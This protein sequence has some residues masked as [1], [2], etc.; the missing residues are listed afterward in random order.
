MGSFC[1]SGPQTTTT[2]QSQTYT[3]NPQIAAAGTQALGMAQSAA[4]QPFQM[5]AAPVA[6]FNPFQTQAFDQYQ[7]IQGGTNPF[8]QN[9]SANMTTAQSPVNQQDVAGFENPYADQALANMKKYVFDPQRR[10]TMGQATK[11]AGGVGADRLALTSQ[12]LDKTQ[13]DAVGS[14]QAGFYG[15]A[16]SAAQQSKQQALQSAQGWANL[17]VGQQG[18]QLQATGALAG[19]G[20]QQQQQQQRELMS[21]YEQMLARIAYPYQNAQF[22][23]GITGGLSGAMGGTTSGQGTQNNYA[24]TPSMLNQIMGGAGIGMAAYGLSQNG[25]QTGG[26]QTTLNPS[27]NVGGGYYDGSGNLAPGPVNY[28]DG[29][30]VDGPSFPGG[31]INPIPYIPLQ[32]T[33]GQAHNNLNLNPTKTDPGKSGG[34]SSQAMAQA[35]KM[36]MMFMNRGGTASGGPVNPW[37]MGQ[38]FGPGGGVEEV[39]PEDYNRIDDQLGRPLE[40]EAPSLGMWPFNRGQADAQGNVTMFPE[41]KNSHD[42]M[43]GGPARAVGR[44]LGIGNPAQAA[45]SP[46]VPQEAP[47]TIPQQGM[48][49]FVPQDQ[50]PQQP[51]TSP[52]NPWSVPPNAGTMPMPDAYRTPLPPAIPTPAPQPSTVAQI[53]QSTDRTGGYRQ[54]GPGGG[55]INSDMKISDFEMPKAGQPYPDAL[56]RDAGQRMARSPW[57]ALLHGAAKTAQSTKNGIAGIA[58][59]VEAGAN[60]L[61]T[62]RKELRSEQ[63][64]NQRAEELYRHAKSELNKYTRKTPH[65][66]A[67]ETLARQRLN[68][69]RYQWQPGT[70]IDPATGQTVSG[71]YR[72]PTRQG[73]QPI[74]MPGMT[75][76]GKGGMNS[77]ALLRNID[78]L[79]AAGIAPNKEAAFGLLH[80]SVNSPAVYVRLV[81]A[82]EKILKDDPQWI[83]K[84]TGERHS[85]A[86]RIVKGMQGAAAT[87]QPQAQPGSTQES[88]IPDPG[89][90]NRVSGTW[91]VNPATGKPDRWR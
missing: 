73:E 20:A 2:N 76:T 36:A 16:L 37:D 56:S 58:E 26:M 59:G 79:V 49:P 34:D 82:Q 71:A 14:A 32:P 35:A 57:M 38:G 18:A 43:T 40:R 88:A 84:T 23:A 80:Q 8:F 86:E 6:G 89:D 55:G 87:V 52:S 17:G 12:N 44:W 28:A 61:D 78:G 7:D 72:L 19:A 63:Q 13:A 30:E 69:E 54:R 62:Q 45:Q 33:S 47:A 65:E 48:P 1:K 21:P 29:G 91:Y 27:G 74:F 25:D 85:E 15:Q 9:A 39:D 67:N 11:M 51:P 41:S 53:P 66:L 90:G 10:N 5:P 75:I 50:K 4:S 77:T 83:G 22:L 42:P 68:Q 81:Q 46:F 70:G 60:H 64:I 3:P 24:A 31:D